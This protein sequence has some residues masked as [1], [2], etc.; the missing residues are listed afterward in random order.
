MPTAKERT[1]RIADLRWRTYLTAKCN[2]EHEPYFPADGTYYSSCGYFRRSGLAEIRD[3]WRR[4]T[5]LM[6]AGKAPRE[7][8][9]YVHWPFCVSRCRF[10]FCSMG[11][12]RGS[13]EMRD[14]AAG[15]RREIDALRGLFH[16]VE[17]SSV[18]FGGGTPTL[19]PDGVL[20]DLLG[21]ISRSF[22][23]RPDAE[24]YVEASPGT[25][26]ASKLKLLL[27]RG[28]NRITLG[29]QS[30]D[31]AVLRR[32]DRRGQTRAAVNAALRRLTA[33]RG[34]YSGVELMFGLEGQTLRS[35]LRDLDD[36]MRR[37]LDAVYLFGFDPRP[38][39]P[40]AQAGQT[41]SPRIRE[42][43]VR[44]LPAL[45]RLARLYGYRTPSGQ[46]ESPGYLRTISSQCRVARRN[47]AS[48]LGLGAGALSHAF[49]AAWYRHPPIEE[50]RRRWDR[51]LPFFCME[52][53]PAEE[54]RGFAVRH[55][56]AQGSIPRGEFRRLFGCDVLDTPLA[57]PLHAAQREGL[58][59]TNGEAVSFTGTDRAQ[60]LVFSKRLYSPRLHRRL[61]AAHHKDFQAFNRR[62]SDRDIRAFLPVAD[63]QIAAM[64]TTFERCRKD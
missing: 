21:H 39:T 9:L 14:Y 53:P 30:L 44:L 3:F 28:V 18:Y 23:L 56:Y 64:M 63:K 36:I 57:R 31:P 60:R 45:E 7:I 19:A 27:R 17:F 38:Q 22:R 13:A 42:G 58:I 4:T 20:D 24:L 29:V 35:F 50:T 1:A 52:S 48:I 8:G 54:M 37:G 49:G 12:A 47:G 2:D 62:H 46:A 26:T 16:E 15:I 5:A 61:K 32:S 33:A 25:L 59:R 43:K 11:A 6:R 10:C 41:L 55:L 51:A 40:F 34:V